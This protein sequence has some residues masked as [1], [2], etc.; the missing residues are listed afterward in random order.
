MPPRFHPVGMFFA[1]V[2]VSAATLLPTPSSVRSAAACLRTKLRSASSKSSCVGSNLFAAPR[3]IHDRN[4]RTPFDVS[5]EPVPS[6]C[7]RQPMRRVLIRGNDAFRKA[8][9]LMKSASSRTLREH[10]NLE[11]SFRR[12]SGG[13]S[14]CQAAGSLERAARLGC[15]ASGGAVPRRPVASGPDGRGRLRLSWIPPARR[16]WQ[17]N[18]HCPRK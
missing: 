12:R 4:V 14:A 6:L 8:L 13:S 16:D 1:A 11:H 9:Q 17:K 7:A 10:R 18:P 15:A 5:L 3:N 2:G